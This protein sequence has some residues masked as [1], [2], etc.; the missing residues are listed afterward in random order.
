VDVQQPWDD[1]AILRELLSERSPAN[2]DS[3]RA[4]LQSCDGFHAESRQAYYQDFSGFHITPEAHASCMEGL[5]AFA[6]YLGREREAQSE[7]DS[8]SELARA[9]LALRSARAWQVEVF[10]IESNS[11]NPN[12]DRA[13]S[14]EARD[15]GMYQTLRWQR[16]H[17]VPEER[18]MLWAHNSHIARRNGTVEGPWGGAKD[19]GQHLSEDLGDA[20]RAVGLVGYDVHINWPGQA[21]G[22]F[23]PVRDPEAVE[24]HLHGL[25]LEV[26]LVDFHVEPRELPFDP[27]AKQYFAHNFGEA[28]PRAQFDGILFID[29][30]AKMRALQW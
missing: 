21:V 19:L 1:Y 24:A 30:V 5:D 3:L 7:G 15:E 11:G 28:I 17:R 13:R 6:D 23:M 25:G 2:A 9:E 20:Y 10:Y 8:P 26:A 29:E 18:V 22:P 12:V 14:F 4:G 16:E 27:T